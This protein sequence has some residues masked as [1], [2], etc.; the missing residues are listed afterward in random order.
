MNLIP[1]RKFQLRTSLTTECVAQNLNTHLQYSA[2]LNF[3]SAFTDDYP[4]T[5]GKK[6]SEF[7]IKKKF[8]RTKIRVG[9]QIIT[10][11]PTVVNVRLFF[12]IWPFLPLI[13][14]LMFVSIITIIFSSLFF[15]FLLYLILPIIVIQY[16]VL[17]FSIK[18]NAW[19]F[20]DLLRKK[21]LIDRSR[22]E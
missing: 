18:V 3:F 2:K 19:W 15:L 8:G 6:G 5:G 17:L 1:N 20:E 12:S 7:I 14:L 13:T 9:I 4:I 11:Q 21:I 10:Q 16:F 22:K